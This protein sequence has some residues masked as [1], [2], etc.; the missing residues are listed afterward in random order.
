M[1]RRRII[2]TDELVDEARIAEANAQR[3]HDQAMRLKNAIDQLI[4]DHHAEVRKL[5]SDV[6]WAYSV[7]AGLALEVCELRFALQEQRGDA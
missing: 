1:K 7:N 5:Q 4:L 6:Q 3:W 2:D